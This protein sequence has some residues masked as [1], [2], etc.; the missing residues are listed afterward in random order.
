MKRGERGERCVEVRCPI[1]D[2]TRPIGDATRPTALLTLTSFTMQAS[3]A[4][5]ERSRRVVLVVAKIIDRH[6]ILVVLVEPAR[7]L[8]LV[9][10]VQR[11]TQQES[12]LHR[13]S[14]VGQPSVHRG[15]GVQTGEK[16]GGAA[17]ASEASPRY[18]RWNE[19]ARR[20]TP[21]PPSQRTW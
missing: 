2:A 5:L 10:V 9:V 7:L 16:G 4:D 6:V 20:N 21:F 17:L 1:G 3:N 15:N 18:R 8:L 14:R 12:L 19:A 13:R 11:Q